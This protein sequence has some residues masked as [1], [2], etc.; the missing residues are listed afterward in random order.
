MDVIIP[1]LGLTMESAELTG[2]LVQDGEL[3]VLDQPIAEIATDKVEH[4]IVSP[5]GGRIRL[6]VEVG[7]DLSVGTVIAT[8]EP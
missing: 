3:V 5:D 7:Q 1:Q 2:W 4:E 8:L 6:L